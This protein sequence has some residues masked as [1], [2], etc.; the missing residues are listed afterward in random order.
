MIML[1]DVDLAQSRMIQVDRDEHEA[2]AFTLECR[3]PEIQR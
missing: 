1:S 2:L 3:L